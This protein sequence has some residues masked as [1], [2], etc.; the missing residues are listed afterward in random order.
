MMEAA[1]LWALLYSHRSYCVL[2]GATEAKAEKRLESIQREL[3]TN[4]LLR[5][6]FP[7]VTYPIWEMGNSHQQACKFQTANDGEPTAIQWTRKH[8]VLPSVRK[9]PNG[10]WYPTSGSVLQMAGITG[11]IRGMTHKTVDGRIIRP[12]LAVTDDPQTRESAKSPTQSET[13][14]Q[15]IAA[16]IAYL[17]GPGQPMSVLVPCT[18]IYPNDM[19]DQILN[20]ELHPEY[21]GIRTRMVEKWPE[22]MDLWDQYAEIW[23][24]SLRN[25]GDMAP[26]TEFYRLHRSNMDVGFEVSWPERYEPNELSAIQHAM[27]WKIRD[28]DAFWS[29]FQNEPREGTADAAIMATPAEVLAKITHFQHRQCPRDATVVTAMIDPKLTCLHWMV[30]AWSPGM[31]GQI[32]DYGPWPP[33]GSGRIFGAKS[34]R[35]LFDDAYP[36]RQQKEQIYMALRDCLLSIGRVYPVE[37]G[38]ELSIDRVLVDAN[39][40]QI[41][42]TIYQCCRQHSQQV[43]F[44]LTPSHGKYVSASSQPWS[45]LKRRKGEKIGPHWRERRSEEWPIRHVIMDVNHWKTVVH[46]L[47]KA[48]FGAVGTLGLYGFGANGQKLGERHHRE[49]ADQICSEYPVR[50]EAK[51]RVVFEWK[52]RPN[53]PDNEGLDLL[54]GCAVAASMEGIELPGQQHPSR[55]QPAERISFRESYR[56]NVLKLS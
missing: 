3:Q 46:T 21:Q 34:L 33:Q 37:G 53:H 17:S 55:R 45:E 1:C 38:G 30:V 24:D 19:A 23:R 31:N 7:E 13:R 56:K 12:S 2:I 52:E 27:N 50:V 49:L 14:A 18:V 4:P 9:K 41:T 29:E 51:E 28:E 15:T 54:V 43:G 40:G 32:I 22:N 16:D 39:M 44:K 5:A 42:S 36:H 47:I 10:A 25:D 6:D 48:D 26:A 20:R 11:D 8:L 35:K